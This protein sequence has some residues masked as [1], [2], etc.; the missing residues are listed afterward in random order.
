M[1]HKQ[2]V[3]ICNWN[4]ISSYVTEN[5]LIKTNWLPICI[6]GSQWYVAEYSIFNNNTLIE[7]TVFKIYKQ[8]ANGSVTITA[9]VGSIT[10]GYCSQ[11]H[12]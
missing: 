4:E 2:N 5:D 3:S 9:P 1:A 12:T 6:G 11:I 10:E 8:G 7:S